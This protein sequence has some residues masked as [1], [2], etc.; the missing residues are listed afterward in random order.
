VAGLD[1]LAGDRF[2]ARVAAHFTDGWERLDDYNWERQDGS[3]QLE[4]GPQ[5]FMV[6]HTGPPSRGW[7]DKADVAACAHHLLS[8]PRL[9]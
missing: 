1:D 4:I 6:T 3:F 9:A 2:V 8:Q 5:H 7:R